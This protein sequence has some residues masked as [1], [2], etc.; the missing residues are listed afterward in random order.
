MQLWTA[1]ERLWYFT[2]SKTTAT[3]N[4]AIHT[5]FN[6]L[7]TYG[8]SS[9][10]ITESLTEWTVDS[11]LWFIFL[12]LFQVKQGTLV[13]SFFIGRIQKEKI[14]M[15]TGR[16]TNVGFVSLKHLAAARFL[17]SSVIATVMTAFARMWYYIKTLKKND[18][19]DRI[20]RP[21]YTKNSNLFQVVKDLVSCV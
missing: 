20:P 10:P 15:S 18:I 12:D 7:W 5:D 11:F 8:N 3:R 1:L 4:V 2:Y 14:A 6:F 17:P 13:V 19:T 16:L 21:W 9:G